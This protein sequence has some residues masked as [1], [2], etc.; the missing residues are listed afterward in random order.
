MKTKVL[1]NIYDLSPANDY[2]FPIGL[3]LYHSGLEIS[4]REYSY[5]SGGSG[6]FETPPKEAPGARFRCQVDLGS[7]DGGTKELNEA[8]DDLRS[9]GGFGSNGYHLVKRNCNHFCNAL[10]RRLLGRPIPPYINRLADIGNFCSCL[11]PKQLLEDS[12]VGGGG[13][14]GRQSFVVPTGAR[15]NRDTNEMSKLVFAGKGHSLGGESTTSMTSTSESD[16]LFSRFTRGSSVSTSSTIPN[17]DLKD[18][19]EKARKA[20]LARLERN[21]AQQLLDKQS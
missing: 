9:N 16:G 3:G 20:A 17:D 7:F 18:R 12:P 2:L 21:Q 15:M 4:G 19:R 13:E 5:G 14:G 6:I 8:L 1:L 10:S 11:L